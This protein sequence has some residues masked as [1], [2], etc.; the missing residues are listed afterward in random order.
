MTVTEYGVSSITSLSGSTSCGTG[1]NTASC[2][3]AAPQD[4]KKTI[5]PHLSTT[6]TWAAKSW[7]DSKEGKT[8]KIAAKTPVPPPPPPG[9]DIKLAKLTIFF[10][11]PSPIVKRCVS[12]A[13]DCPPP[14][15]P[16]GPKNTNIVVGPKP[17][18]STKPPVLGPTDPVEPD[19]EG[20]ENEEDDFCLLSSSTKEPSEPSEPT[21]TKKPD[22]TTTKAPEPTTTK[23]PDPPPVPPK[24]KPDF[25]KDSKPKCY[26]SG[27]KAKRAS[28]I[29]A[30]T[31][32]CRSVAGG[33]Y[34]G[35]YLT[36][37][38]NPPMASGKTYMVYTTTLEVKDGCE[39]TVDE[40]ECGQE[41]RKIVDGCDT[42]GENSKQGGTMDGNC[43][44]W[45]IDP[46][47]VTVD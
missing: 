35:S 24:N 44:K 14:T 11:P 16:P 31:V 41:L 38:D 26:D 42:S 46:D 17:D 21:T 3:T 20:D 32:A 18:P 47:S 19:E 13:L 8:H 15:G 28:M 37:V 12:P 7:K 2:T 33:K 43:I 27:D 5:P 45:R 30:I 6:R 40:Y 29:E 39:W 22:P 34:N 9:L 25:S 23:K 4:T 1:T 10:G 36:P